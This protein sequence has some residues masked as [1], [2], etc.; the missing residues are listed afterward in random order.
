MPFASC[1][2]TE[3]KTSIDAFSSLVRH[4]ARHNNVVVPPRWVGGLGELRISWICTTLL[5]DSGEGLLLR[6]SDDD[7]VFL[8]I[9]CDACSASPPLYKTGR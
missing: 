7:V 8:P 6:Q 2:G 3:N 4:S 9:T 1:A 5:A